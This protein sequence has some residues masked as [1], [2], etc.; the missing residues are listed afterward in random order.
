MTE[1]K[2]TKRAVSKPRQLKV[3]VETIKE[4]DLKV[5]DPI[6]KLLEAIR[7]DIVAASQYGLT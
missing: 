4:H 7:A 2:P 6:I 5:D 1:K 3:T